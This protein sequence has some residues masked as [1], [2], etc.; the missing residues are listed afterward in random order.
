MARE[1]ESVE[2]AAGRKRDESL[3]RRFAGDLDDAARRFADETEAEP[4]DDDADAVRLL[5]VHQAKGLEFRAVF[6]AGMS[7]GS[8]PLP[9]PSGPLVRPAELAPLLRRITSAPLPWPESREEHLREERRL[10][11]VAATRARDRLFFTRAARTHDDVAESPFFAALRAA[12]PAEAALDNPY[13]RSDGG[14]DPSKPDALTRQEIEFWLRRRVT[15]AANRDDLA[16][17]IGAW[18]ASLPADRRLDAD[19]VT[20]ARR[21]ERANDRAVALPDSLRLSATSLRDWLACPRRFFYGHLLDVETEETFSASFGSF[22]HEVLEA[23]HRR[24]ASLSPGERAAYEK[25]ILEIAEERFVESREAFPTE[26]EARAALAIAR[27]ILPDYVADEVGRALGRTTLWVEE[28]LAFD[29]DGHAIEAKIDRVDRVADGYEIID[30]K[31]S[32]AALMEVGLRRMFLPE[33]DKPPSNFQ[34]PLYWLALEKSKGVKAAALV[35]HYVRARTSEGKPKRARLAI[36]PERD[37][38]GLSFEDLE[39]AARAIRS[40]IGE[41]RRGVFEPK[42]VDPSQCREQCDFYGVC[43]RQG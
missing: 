17:R 23:F 37:K 16:R 31:T 13:G 36:R 19:Y 38:K 4:D 34:L 28:R 9:I 25:E 7:E 10:A 22:V 12:L 42:P 11:Y 1:Y 14:G 15:S 20:G 18:N 43:Y 3:L 41:I 8:F 39:A 2:R 26:M 5:T 35:V 33:G 21:F 32:A 30:Y 6:V 29:L 27:D 24:H 40:T